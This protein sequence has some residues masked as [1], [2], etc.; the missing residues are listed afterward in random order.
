MILNLQTIS[1]NLLLKIAAKHVW[2][3]I[4]HSFTL[5]QFIGETN[6]HPGAIAYH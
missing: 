2:V 1:T 6:K 4:A 3:S 5:I